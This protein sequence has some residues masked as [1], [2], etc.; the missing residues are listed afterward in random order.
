MRRD[1]QGRHDYK[2]PEGKKEA[3]KTIQYFWR[4][5]KSKSLFQQLMLYRAEK[6]QQLVYFCQQVKASKEPPNTIYRLDRET[7][8]MSILRWDDDISGTWISKFKFNRKKIDVTSSSTKE[9]VD[10]ECWSVSSQM[11]H[12]TWTD[13]V[14]TKG[15]YL[16]LSESYRMVYF[17]IRRAS[18]MSA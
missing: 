17:T 6:Q 16:E 9:S 1:S 15:M 2:G 10:D 5:W 14:A 11:E 4:K 3:A 13:Q 18:K 7:C 8:L 12:F